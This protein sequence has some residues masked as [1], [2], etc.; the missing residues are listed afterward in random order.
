MMFALWTQVTRLRLFLTAKSCRSALPQERGTHKGE[1][2]DALR[3]GAGH[4][5]ERLDDA[6]RRTVLE[7]CSAQSRRHR[8]RRTGVLALG[9][10][11]D[12]DKVDI[13]M[14]RRQARQRL[15]ERDG[16]V[17]VELLPE[18]DVPGRVAGSLLRRVEDALEADLVP[19]QRVERELEVG[20]VRARLAG[21]FVLVELDGH[22][23]VLEHL[24]DRVGH[25]DTDTVA[26]N[27]RDS[28]DA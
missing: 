5:L 2:S 15:A 14:A 16:G 3:F 17:D 18:R 23:D 26:R 6:G 10:L 8:C 27:Q 9:V 4:D 21:D 20:L 13:L 1:A 22:V 25:L 11:A 19:S 7:T 28:V 12:D 24:L